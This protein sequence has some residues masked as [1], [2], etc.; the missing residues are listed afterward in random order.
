MPLHYKVAANRLRYYR[1]RNRLAST[2]IQSIARG[3]RTRNRKA[4]GGL[5]SRTVQSNRKLI[6]KLKR[7]TEVKYLTAS[8]ALSTNNYT[9]QQAICYPDCVGFN[10]RLIGIN[11]LTPGTPGTAPPAFVFVPTIIR[12]LFC[13]QGTDEGQRIGEYISMKWITIK[14]RI[15]AA[16]ASQ[17][18]TAPNGSVYTSRPMMQKVHMV[19]ALDSS[20]PQWD[21]QQSPQTF[22]PNAST[23][24]M[25]NMTNLP[26]ATPNPITSQRGNEFLRSGGKAP[27]GSQTQINSYDLWDKSFWENDYVCS[28]KYKNKRF[29]ILKVVTLTVQQENANNAPNSIPD[30]KSFSYTLKLPYNFQYSNVNANLPSNQELVIFLSSNVRVPIGA[31]DNTPPI[32]PPKVDIQCKVAFTDA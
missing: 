24:Y 27:F 16:P 31:T 28:K 14:G 1:R 9:G 12:P 18:G 30:V 29:K 5:V 10:N 13:R 3:W 21:G 8:P 17:N 7:K 19:V 20:P 6:K 26:Y 25:Y 32:P 11:P 23:G 15:S 22:Q 4:K 2:R